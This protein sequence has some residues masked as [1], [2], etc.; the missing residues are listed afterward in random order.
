[1]R[2]RRPQP[3]LD[4]LELFASLRRRDLVE[5]DRHFDRL[6]A[7]AGA[8]LLRADRSMD[9]L[10]VVHAGRLLTTTDGGPQLIGPGEAFGVDE[11]LGRRRTTGSLVAAVDSDV[12]VMRKR[13]F[14]G[15][16]DT[17]PGFAAALVA[18]GFASSPADTVVNPLPLPAR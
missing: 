5:L 15:A 10:W 6:H 2:T 12:L 4:A 1:M 7:P 18:P 8:V 16:L 9:W 13:E 3:D 14:L 17:I 11:L